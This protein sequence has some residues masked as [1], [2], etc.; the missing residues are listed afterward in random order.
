MAL[1]HRYEDQLIRRLPPNAQH[2]AELLLS[3]TSLA[4]LLV[5]RDAQ[6]IDLL[7]LAQ[8]NV[9]VGLWSD[10]VQAALLAR[11][12]Y[13]DPSPLLDQEKI[14]LLVKL[15]I[16]TIGFSLTTPLPQVVTAVKDHYPRLTAWL[17]SM[18][19]LLSKLKRSAAE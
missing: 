1:V 9:P 17:V 11:I 14:L 6:Q 8:N 16:E 2:V 5:I 19:Q 13:F 4:E 15:A 10:I 18:A 12:T 3:Q 7:L